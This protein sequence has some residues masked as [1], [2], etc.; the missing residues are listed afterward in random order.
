MMHKDDFLISAYDVRIPKIIYGTAWEKD[1][2]AELVPE[3]IGLGFRGI[4][5]ACQPKHYNESGVG[6]ALD[7]CFQ[8]GLKRSDI[9]LQSKFTPLNGHDPER[10]PYDLN[11]SLSEQVAES[12]QVSLN[13]LCTDYLDCLVLNSPLGEWQQTSEV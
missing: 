6:E 12:F 8:A 4:D 7:T 10:I 11:G 2:T 13:N 1:R 9:Y 5:T 3:A